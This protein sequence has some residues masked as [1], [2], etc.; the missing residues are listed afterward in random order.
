MSLRHIEARPLQPYTL[1]QLLLPRTECGS[2]GRGTF[3]RRLTRFEADVRLRL[4]LRGP[5]SISGDQLEVGTVLEKNC[6][7]G[8]IGIE[9][10]SIICDHGAGGGVHLTENVNR[11]NALAMK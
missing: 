3:L 10:D 7:G 1:P 9:T 11:P 8:L 4:N 5:Y 2:I 6:A